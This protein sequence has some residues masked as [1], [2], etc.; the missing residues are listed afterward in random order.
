MEEVQLVLDASSEGMQAAID[1]LAVELS[2]IR[3]GKA[4]PAMLE[5][6]LVDYY[7]TL[8]PISQVA[9]LSAPDGRTLVVQ[10]WEKNMLSVIE[11]AIIVSN[12]G[13]NPMNDGVLLRIQVPSLTEERRR[14]LV[15]MV[16]TVGENT[17]VAIRNARRDANEE[18]KKMKKDG[19]AEDVCKN[20]EDSVQKFTDKFIAKVD[21]LMKVKEDDIMTV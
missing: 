6:V 12:L 7:G 3:A 2:K 13:F 8:T 9:N 1:R 19:T 14:D 18:L 11:K 15:K 20:A 17:K 21:E 5:S 16:R 10:P 4:S